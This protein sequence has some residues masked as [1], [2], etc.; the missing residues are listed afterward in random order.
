MKFKL[1]VYNNIRRYSRSTAL[2]CDICKG[3]FTSS[4]GEVS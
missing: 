3:H 1:D 2:M 4:I